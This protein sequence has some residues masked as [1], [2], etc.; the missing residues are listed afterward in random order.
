MVLLPLCSKHWTRL[1]KVPL[2]AILAAGPRRI[3]A[4]LCFFAACKQQKKQHSH[5]TDAA[6]ARKARRR[7]NAYNLNTDRGGRS[8]LT[9]CHSADE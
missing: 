4:A 7:E 3:K 8:H 1:V 9:G 2:E 5:V 6:A